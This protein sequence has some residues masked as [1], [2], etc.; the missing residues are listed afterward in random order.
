[1][2]D[3]LSIEI[4]RNE[5]KQVDHLCISLDNLKFLSSIFITKI[6]SFKDPLKKDLI[7]LKAIIKK[8]PK[9]FLPK[10]DL[11]SKGEHLFNKIHR[12]FFKDI[13]SVNYIVLQHGALDNSC[14]KKSLEAWEAILN[15]FLFE[16]DF[17]HYFNLCTYSI[18]TD[19]K[20]MTFMELLRKVYNSP[21]LFVESNE[22]E[23][24]VKL[25]T[26]TL[27]KLGSENSIS[28]KW[29][30]A[31]LANYS[32]DD[33]QERIWD[34]ETNE[35]VA[36]I[37]LMLKRQKEVNLE[38][39]TEIIPMLISE[40]IIDMK[41]KFPFRIIESELK[42]PVEELKG[43]IKDNFLSESED[44]K[45]LELVSNRIK[46]KHDVKSVL[47]PTAC[48]KEIKKEVKFEGKSIEDF[49]NIYKNLPDL[50]KLVTHKEDPSKLLE[51]YKKFMEMVER[52]ISEELVLPIL[53]KGQIKLIMIYIEKHV[54]TRLYYRYI[55]IKHNSL[56]PAN[57]SQNDKKLSLRFKEMNTYPLESFGIKKEFYNDKFF[58]LIIESNINSLLYRIEEGR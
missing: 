28:D 22:K 11:F 21:E 20:G 46:K 8:N 35:L 16:V 30:S 45:V 29:I 2:N 32:K 55:S 39:E 6:N 57:P 53:D 17:N 12:N 50:T 10:K 14:K 52:A 42:V 26:S 24:K 58:N 23:L 27:M 13:K 38:L 56:F 25:I 41:K 51:L 33:L 49:I 19:K 36:E 31:L 7:Q 3:L 34:N 37:E 44:K 54:L 48:K 5:N 15:E 1:M 43:S 9:L 47:K 4:P 40:H 18:D